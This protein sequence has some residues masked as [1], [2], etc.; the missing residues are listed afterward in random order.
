MPLLNEKPD[1]VLL[2]LPSRARQPLLALPYAPLPTSTPSRM[3]LLALP[4][5]RESLRRIALGAAAEAGG[6]SVRVS[7]M[8]RGPLPIGS[9]RARAAAARLGGSRRPAGAEGG[10][11]L[12]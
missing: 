8:S 4:A 12:V 11:P 2:L 6:D 5:P 7:V 10:G 3:A 1:T 9:L